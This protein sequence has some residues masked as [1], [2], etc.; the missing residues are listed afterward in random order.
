[1]MIK[2]FSLFILFSCLLFTLS[3]A[4]NTLNNGIYKDIEI[5][6]LERSIDATQTSIVKQDVKLTIQN[7]GS[8]ETKYFYL[9]FPKAFAQNVAH[10]I[11]TYQNNNLNI[12]KYAFQDEFNSESLFYQVELSSPLGSN[13][14]VEISL[15]IALLNTI[16]PYP[17]EIKQDEHQKVVYEDNL[18]FYSPYRIRT[19]QTIV[20]LGTSIIE[21]YSNTIKPA[22]NRG[23]TINYGPYTNVA[24]FSQAELKVHYQ[25][26]KPWFVISSLDRIVEISHWG[27]LAIEEH[28]EIKH[29]GAKLVGAFSRYEYSK[30]P[31]Q[32]SPASFRKITAVLPLTANEIYFRDRIGNISSSDIRVVGDH[33]EV[34]FL[35]R[36]PLFGGWS[37][38]FY[39]GYNVPLSDYLTVAKNNPEKY[40][41]RYNFGSPFDAPIEK[42]TLKVVIPEGANDLEFRVP[43]PI[44]E[45]SRE[46]VKTYLDISGRPVV[47]VKKNNVS[48]DQQN[49]NFLVSYNF[50]ASGIY[51][52]PLLVIGSLFAFCV[53]VMFY[54]RLDLT[55]QKSEEQNEQDRDTLAAELTEEF[56]ELFIKRD[57][58]YSEVETA[59]ANNDNV[60][61]IITEV[62]KK[63]QEITDYI[64]N[65]I[66]SELSKFNAKSL[67]YIGKIEKKETEKFEILRQLSGIKKRGGK[68]VEKTIL[69]LEDNYDNATDEIYDA[70]DVLRE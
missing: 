3:F 38:R 37:I 39:I 29:G 11:V 61:K 21:S 55:I 59:I 26:D 45:E 22:E 64:R 49:I 57:S 67:S 9:A 62:E 65:N 23:T 44:D 7:I 13:Q 36:F 66:I 31:F 27:N 48:P 17:K 25:N 5:I 20:K 60:D 14:K 47:V 50:P 8:S 10:L 24:P 42:L 19:Q 46:V 28:Y 52:E 12:I 16:R 69:E 33:L 54:V 56:I 32:T 15:N 35:P 30:N 51:F 4:T 18:Y 58:Y 63:R 41:L 70:V 2:Y 6:S 34:D 53:F 40:R 43:F 68:D 1:M